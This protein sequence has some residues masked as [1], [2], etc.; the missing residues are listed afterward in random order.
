MYYSEDELIWPN[1]TEIIAAELSAR[2]F[3]VTITTWPQKTQFIPYRGYFTH[4]DL[5]WLKLILSDL[6]FSWDRFYHFLIMELVWIR[7]CAKNMFDPRRTIKNGIMGVIEHCIL[8]GKTK[9]AAPGIECSFITCQHPE[10]A[11]SRYWA[12][13]KIV[14][15]V[16]FTL[17]DTIYP[18]FIHF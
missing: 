17:T 16:N 6:L 14:L 15:E 13:L 3:N 1:Y 10:G 11:I 5:L 8:F 7:K 4:K 12:Y 2:P 9:N 18:I